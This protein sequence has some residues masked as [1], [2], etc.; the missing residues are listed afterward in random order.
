MLA[1][2][3]FIF[4]LIE[5]KCQIAE[6]ESLLAEVFPRCIS[7]FSDQNEYR[8]PYNL[9][10]WIPLT[11][12]TLFNL[13]PGLRDLCPKPWR[14]KSPK[15][16]EN[17][18]YTGLRYS[19]TGGGFVADLGYNATSARKVAKYLEKNVWIDSS[20]AVVFAELTVFE[21]ATSL[22]SA[23]KYM[24]ERFPSGGSH[25]DIR[26]DTL[27]L[28]YPTDPSFRSFFQVCQLLMML[29]IFIF[30]LLQV[31][32]IYLNGRKYFARFW[33][34]VELL[35][36]IGATSA[37]VM[38]FFKEKYAS[39]F[40]KRV[41]ANPFETSNTDY[42]VLW[43]DLETTLLS[44]VI[45][46]VTIKL[47]SLLRFNRHICQMTGTLK[48]C[49]KHMVSFSFIF[50][51]L[52]LAFTQLVILVFGRNIEV[53]SSFYNSL[54]SLLLMLV[55]GRMYLNEAAN[56]NPVLGRLFAFFYMLCMLVTI[57]NMFCAILCDSHEEVKDLQGEEFADA[58]LG[59]FMN[60]YLH[61]WIN[62]IWNSTMEFFKERKS[63]LIGKH[64]VEQKYLRDE[65]E[66]EEEEDDYDYDNDNDD[67]E[68]EHEHDHDED[69]DVDLMQEKRK[70][71]LATLAEEE[72]ASDHDDEK[73]LLT[74]T[75]SLSESLSSLRTISKDDEYVMVD[76]PLEYKW[77][78]T[79]DHEK[80]VRTIWSGL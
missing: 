21:P 40:V 67:H 72:H 74:I 42:I 38:F 73:E 69:D 27:T 50:I 37:V 78:P 11:N 51:G 17:R 5:I 39:N 68:H 56:V 45:F 52:I 3:P 55:G 13:I 22:F 48:R 44:F 75:Q 34:W 59:E 60:D 49:A 58:E 6:S 64:D 35:F 62:S 31:I 53:Y 16:L 61:N 33:N 41:Q 14:Y 7:Q 57:M 43:A 47:L 9:P 25:T 20:T 28:Y 77:K 10:G 76:E 65:D 63:R 30:L 36:I 1:L 8:T 29:L 4:I 46:L 24:Y 71:L 2:I 70:S 19:Y 18:G 12:T 80:E 32:S 23:V 26:V 66:D 54:R 79:S 15:E